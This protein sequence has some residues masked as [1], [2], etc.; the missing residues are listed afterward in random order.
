MSYQ[1]IA[2]TD[3]SSIDRT[4][5]I[6][7]SDFRK[8]GVKLAQK[9]LDSS[10]AFDAITAPGTK[11][12]DFDLAMWDWV[13]LLDPDFMLSVVTCG[14]F[15]GWSDSGFCDKKYDRMYTQQQLTPDQGKRR[16]I[17]REMQKYLYEKRPYL[18]LATLDHVSAVNSKWVGLAYSPQG[19]VNPLSKLSLTKV[20][21]T[22]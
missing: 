14:Q 10:A 2:P 17:V 16:Q 3:V 15:G 8:I 18:W 20:H 12:L 21:Q 13:G 4:F 22:G 9:A 7:Q 19:P 11:Y 5:Q 6:L 1:V